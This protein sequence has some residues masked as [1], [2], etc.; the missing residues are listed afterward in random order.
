MYVDQIEEPGRIIKPPSTEEYPYEPYAFLDMQ[1]VKSYG[2]KAE[3]ECEDS[4]Y[5]KNKCIVQKYNDQDPHKS[6]LL[7][8]DITWSYFQDKFST[9]HYVGV[10]GD[11]GER[12][13][14]S[15]RYF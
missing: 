8:A 11:N 14:Y 1:E 3:K 9:T 10:I 7:A 6:I 12:K 4:L 2:E 5:K 13:G 15:R